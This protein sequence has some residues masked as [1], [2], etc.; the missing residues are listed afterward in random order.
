MRAV[1]SSGDGSNNR[2]RVPLSFSDYSF[3]SAMETQP[4]GSD[5]VE[6]EA[7]GDA[8]AATTLRVSGLGSIDGP[9][10]LPFLL[11]PRCG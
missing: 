8:P 10:E 7:L 9:L 3:D 5:E 4:N 11:Y 2:R 6:L 1:R